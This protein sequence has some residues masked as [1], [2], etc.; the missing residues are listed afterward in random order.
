MPRESRLLGV[1]NWY[2]MV[3]YFLKLVASRRIHQTYRFWADNL[4]KKVYTNCKL[5]KY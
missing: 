2:V 1:T 5:K 3:H 4:Q